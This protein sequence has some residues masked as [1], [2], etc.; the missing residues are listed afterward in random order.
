MNMKIAQNIILAFVSLFG[1]NLIINQSLNI[2]WLTPGWA[3][4]S[5]VQ[6]GAAGTTV[7]LADR[8]ATNYRALQQ[9]ERDLRAQ[10]QAGTLS[11]A[12]TIDFLD[13]ISQLREQVTAA[14]VAL[15]QAG[16]D[17][18]KQPLCMGTT[19]VQAPTLVEQ[20]REKTHAE[21]LGQHDKQLSQRL[22][23]FDEMM[24]REQ[25]RVKAATP[26]A[27][28]GQGAQAGGSSASSNA[29]A[30]TSATA[31]DIAKHDKAGSPEF[32]NHGSGANQ[33]TQKVTLP[34]PDDVPNG[35]DDD[36]VARQ[37]RE[38]A[39]QESDPAL[40]EKLWD[41]YKKYKQGTR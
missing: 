15:A 28:T 13:Y 3:A 18:A 38:A 31:S 32:S 20:D 25:Q 11:D 17:M 30:Q 22:G 1:M 35:S 19:A 12:E 10:Q 16:Q 41:E 27:Q 26:A 14:C 37:L 24:L 36:L 39:G 7:S 2:I 23:E 40:R 29:G 33:A 34:P 6:V 4:S 5:E 8:L 9:A 21:Q